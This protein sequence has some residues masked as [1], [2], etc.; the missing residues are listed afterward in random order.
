M[1]RRSAA[2]LLGAAV[3]VLMAA[4]PAAAETTS[5]AERFTTSDGVELQTTLTGAAPLAPRPVVVEFSPYGRDSGTLDPGPAYNSLLVQ[6]RGTG[7]SDGRF[8]ALGPRTQA[9]VAEVLHW[10][11]EQPWSDGRLALNGFSASAITIYNSLHRRLPCVRAAV[12]KSGTYEL[13][14]DLLWP[15]GVSNFIP[16]AGVLALIG[17]PAAIQGLDRL[18]RDPGS[19]AEVL[20]GMLEAGLNGGVLHPTLDRWWRQ[21]GFRGDAN[22]LPILMIDGFYDV[23]SRGAFEAYRRLR[24]DGAHLYVIGAHDGA[25]A[26]TDAGVG[27]SRAWLDHYVRG[28]DNGVT[29]HPRV[30]LWLA[31]GDREDLLN[32][33]FARVDGGDWPFP[34]TRWRS[35][36]LDASPSGTANSLNDGSLVLGEPAAGATQSYPAVSS[37]PSSSDPYNT[38][39][40]G[41]LGPNQLAALYPPSTE[42]GAAEPFGL[43]YTTAPFA[44]DVLAAGPASLELRFATTAPQTAIWAVLSDVWADGS[45]HPVAAGRLLTDY[46][47]VIGRKSLRDRGRIVQPYGDYT[48]P[49]P[50]T[51][52]EA[53]RYR[54]ELWPIGNRF[55][56]GHRLRLDLVGASA[57][58]K[59]GAPGV[60]TVTVG[61][62]SG[63]RLLFPVLPG[64]DL[65][66]ALR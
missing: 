47:R 24:D 30:Q 41:G 25:P 3:A 10:A 43:S 61:P 34:G 60:N 54:V 11:C 28:I 31:D 45:A 58:S 5:A 42:M 63:S 2:G 50:A 15:G 12:M 59:P 46:P 37:A 55:E 57:A 64:S 14:R 8:D 16:G 6:I 33:R 29:A 1:S 52:A 39:I 17:A 51:P 22:H 27:E 7:D 26:G 9:D 49:D 38:A 62:G 40:V 36:A 44:S 13:Y 23:E 65:R 32:G 35:L 66:E 53:R 19:G 4:A 48:R 56:A 18:A 20:A 21:R